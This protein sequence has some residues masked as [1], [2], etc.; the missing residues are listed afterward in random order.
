MMQVTLPVSAYTTDI[1]EEMFYD[2]L[3]LIALIVSAEAEN[4]SFYGK[5]LVADVILNRVD[6]DKFPNTITEVIEA[7]GQF[8]TYQNGRYARVDPS[9]ETYLAVSSQVFGERENKEVLYF[10]SVGNWNW[11]FKEGDHFFK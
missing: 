2:E 3:E 10:R 6:S 8:T 1:E 4:Q 11:E 7:P 5:Q 9:P